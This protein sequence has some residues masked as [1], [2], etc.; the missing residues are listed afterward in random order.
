MR[1]SVCGPVLR[2]QQLAAGFEWRCLSFFRLASMPVVAGL[3]VAHGVEQ[4]VGDL[5]HGRDHDD[6]RALPL[7]L[8]EICAATR[9]RSA[10]PMLVPPNFITSRFF[11]G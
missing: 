8:G 2:R 1:A 6:D 5:R 7:L 11:N 3:G 4:Q 10:V 9:M